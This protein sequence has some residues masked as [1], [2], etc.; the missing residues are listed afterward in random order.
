MV[1]NLLAKQFITV[2]LLVDELC[3]RQ[4]MRKLVT[5]LADGCVELTMTMKDIVVKVSE[6]WKG[7]G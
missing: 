5:F 1:L 6:R 4:D 2:P 3:N 7:P